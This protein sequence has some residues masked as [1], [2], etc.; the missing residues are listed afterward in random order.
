[1][2]VLSWGCNKLFN[3]KICTIFNINIEMLHKTVLYHNKVIC[4]YL[5]G[6]YFSRQWLKS[7]DI[8]RISL[9]FHNKSLEKEVRGSGTT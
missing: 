6:L 9:F 7:E 5:Y 2:S 8:Q 3:L 4:F 1:M